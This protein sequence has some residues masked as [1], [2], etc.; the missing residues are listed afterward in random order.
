MES[1]RNIF[2][3]LGDYPPAVSV[4]IYQR[5]FHYMQE[6]EMFHFLTSTRPSL[7]RFIE[8]AF[9]WSNTEEGGMFWAELVD[10]LRKGD[11]IAVTMFI[12]DH[13]EEVIDED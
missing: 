5:L 1:K 7:P 2:Q 9:V 8:G 3:L 6:Q 11:H 13:L 12:R 10:L 4:F